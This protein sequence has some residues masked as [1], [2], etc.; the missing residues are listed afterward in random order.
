M[1][2][3]ALA[4]RVCEALGA[5]VARVEAGGEP[6][7]VNLMP[8]IAGC[9]MPRG[10]ALVRDAVA[11]VT[12][13]HNVVAF[14]DLM[15][16]CARVRLQ[17][18]TEAELLRAENEALRGLCEETVRVLRNEAP[19]WVVGSNLAARIEREL[20]APFAKGGAR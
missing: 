2:A 15:P 10:V 19:L 5:A 13:Q 14:V 12:E 8:I 3:L 11:E 6:E 18:A 20:R 9:D 17:K 16:G 4:E 1:S 7:T